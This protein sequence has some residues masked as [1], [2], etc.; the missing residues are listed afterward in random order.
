MEIEDERRE[1]W[2]KEDASFSCYL[3][4]ALMGVHSNVTVPSKGFCVTFTNCQF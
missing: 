1:V 4:L 3:E 2:K